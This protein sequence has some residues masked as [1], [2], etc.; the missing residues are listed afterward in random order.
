MGIISSWLDWSW[1]GKRMI[2][3][4]WPLLFL[5]WHY[6]QSGLWAHPCIWGQICKGKSFLMGVS[7]DCFLHWLLG[8]VLGQC[9]FLI[10]ILDKDMSKQS[11]LHRPF[12]WLDWSDSRSSGPSHSRLAYGQYLLLP[13]FILTFPCSLNTVMKVLLPVLLTVLPEIVTLFQANLETLEDLLCQKQE[14]VRNATPPVGG[15]F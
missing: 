14:A 8:D 13:L 4:E 10:H 6:D 7:K 5:W 9:P 1:E 12:P 2:H 11:L 15:S 3:R